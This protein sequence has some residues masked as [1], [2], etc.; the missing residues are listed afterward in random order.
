MDSYFDDYR[1]F[2]VFKEFFGV[3]FF[4]G[5]EVGFLVFEVNRV[6]VKSGLK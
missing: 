4:K 1:K 3:F 6:H 5:T 2:T